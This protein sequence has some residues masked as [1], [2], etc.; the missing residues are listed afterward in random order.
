MP[1]WRCLR[2]GHLAF[3]SCTRFSP[4]TRWPAAITGSIASAANVLEIATRVTEAGSRRASAQAREI[5][6]RTLASGG[7]SVLTSAFLMR[8]GVHRARPA[9][10]CPRNSLC[11]VEDDPERMAV[12]RAQ[13]AHPVAHVDAVDAARALHRTVMHGKDNA[14]ALRERH[15]LGARLHARALL[16]EHELAAAEVLARS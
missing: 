5:Y 13:S 1:P 12:P 16:R 15:H 3:A 6:A 10:Q 8:T 4:N 14:L 11:V 7:S 9:A 2:A